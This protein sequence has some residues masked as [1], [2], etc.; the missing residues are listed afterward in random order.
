MFGILSSDEMLSGQH[1]DRCR[2][3]LHVQ[4]PASALSV[5]PL[6]IFVISFPGTARWQHGAVER[7][8]SLAV[9]SQSALPEILGSCLLSSYHAGRRGA[10]RMCGGHSCLPWAPM[11]TSAVGPSRE[12]TQSPPT[13]V[14]KCPPRSGP[15]GVQESHLHLR[16]KEGSE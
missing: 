13:A 1:E 11:G 7:E 2:G 3:V 6:F 14:G 10:I 8:P 12:Q 4:S 16:L 5:H 15:A 9:P